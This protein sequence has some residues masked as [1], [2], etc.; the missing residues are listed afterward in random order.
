MTVEVITYEPPQLTTAM[1]LEED[2][3]LMIDT[4]QEE[5]ERMG[6]Y[7]QIF[8]EGVHDI[9]PAALRKHGSIQIC[10][11]DDNSSLLKTDIE[12]SEPF[13][14][15]MMNEGDVTSVTSTAGDGFI[16]YC[17]VYQQ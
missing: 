7:T 6:V 13:D 1:E 15:K 8:D 14:F 10:V 11:L 16:L 17:V 12:S 5:R 2:I 9:T 3:E 4:E